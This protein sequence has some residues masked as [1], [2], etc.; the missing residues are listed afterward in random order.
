MVRLTGRPDMTIAVYRGHKTTQ[1]QV[2]NENDV[3]IRM[4]KITIHN[5]IQYACSD[6]INYSKKQCVI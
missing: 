6:K 2:L 1:Q 4:K 3:T 5:K